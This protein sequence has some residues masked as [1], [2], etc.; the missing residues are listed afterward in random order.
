MSE[1]TKQQ[2]TEPTPNDAAELATLRMT[3]SELKQKSSTRKAKIAELEATIAEKDGQLAEAT[4]S[5]RKITIDA[6]LSDMSE[7]IS[8]APELWREQLQK[9]YRI[10]HKDGSLI[11]LTQDGKPVHDKDGKEVQFTREAL[12]AFLTNEN[13]PAAKTFK[14]ITIVSRASGGAGAQASTTIPS[15]PKP[16]VQF[17]LR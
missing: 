3:V 9:L 17:G 11:L 1:E 6:P 13:H 2:T 7:A 15:K 14:A 5:L 16:T 8:T 4:A 10:E 12:S